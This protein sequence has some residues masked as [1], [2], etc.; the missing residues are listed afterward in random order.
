MSFTDNAGCQNLVFAP[1]LSSLTLDNNKK[2]SNWISTRIS[3]EKIKTSDTNLEPTM[4]NLPNQY[5]H[6]GSTLFQR[7]GSTLK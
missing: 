3:L 2:V 1:M 6:V 4:S 5:F 7:R